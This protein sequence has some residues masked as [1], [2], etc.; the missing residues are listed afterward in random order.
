M[1]CTALYAI[2]QGTGLQKRDATNTCSGIKCHFS[3]AAVGKILHSSGHTAN[4]KAC[5]AR[6]WRVYMC[7]C[8]CMAR[9]HVHVQ[10]SCSCTCGVA[11]KCPEVHVHGDAMLAAAP[12]YSQLVTDML[13]TVNAWSRHP[14]MHSAPQCG[15]CATYCGSTVIVHTS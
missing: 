7:L 8:L 1:P 14:Q 9:V 5:H 2:Q 11:C 6:A 4:V 12:P 13:P 15:L 3:A 10:R